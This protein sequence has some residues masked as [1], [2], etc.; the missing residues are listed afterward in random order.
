MSP[1]RAP[2]E[3][4]DEVVTVG[5][6][7][8]RM[9][10]IGLTGGI[11]TGKSLAVKELR[12]RGIPVVDAD[13]IAHALQEAGRPVWDSIRARFG[14]WTLEP[15]GQLDRRRVGRVVFHD[16][17]RLRLL[18]DLVHPPVREAIHDEL[19]VLEAGGARLA[20]A[21][22][23]LL[24]ESGWDRELDVIWV[25]SCTPEQQYQ[26]LVGRSGLTR[27]AALRRI[28]AQWPLAEKVARADVVIDNSGPPAAIARQLTEA[29]SAVGWSA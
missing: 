3:W 19:S 10:R 23:P 27:E 17:E 25:V 12:R 7:T 26:R 11:A 24:F 2:R 22:I 5:D 13:R 9:L 16:P 1:G 20:V 28:A 29:L 14:C 21:D 18:N 6:G 8:R 15:G 4:S